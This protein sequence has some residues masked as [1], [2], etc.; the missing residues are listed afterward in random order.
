MDHPFRYALAVEVRDLLE[1]VIVLE[2]G[3]SSISDGALMLIIVDGVSLSRREMLFVGHDHTSPGTPLQ[4]AIVRAVGRKGT[5]ASTSLEYDDRDLR[6][7]RGCQ[8]C[9]MI[10]G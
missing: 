1:E 5:G 7:R 4:G 2:G 8:L 3:R 9:W 6:G 10:M